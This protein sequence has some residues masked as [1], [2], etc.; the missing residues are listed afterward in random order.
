[1]NCPKCGNVMEERKKISRNSFW[2]C[3][4]CKLSVDI[5]YAIV[6]DGGW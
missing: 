1:M 3:K 2:V 5:L 6:D 4:P